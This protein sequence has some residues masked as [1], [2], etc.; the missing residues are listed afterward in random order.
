MTN[1][2]QI[3]SNLTTCITAAIRTTVPSW[4]D[5]AINE[6][7]DGVIHRAIHPATNEAARYAITYA[8][9]CQHIA[10]RNNSD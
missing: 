7:T 3:T 4:E 6:A 8:G 10:E 5:V 1:V 9:F 2:R